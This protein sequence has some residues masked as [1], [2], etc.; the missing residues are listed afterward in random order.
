ML[1][2]HALN[3]GRVV[4][5]L[6]ALLRLYF[7]RVA[8]SS[9]PHMSAAA[10]LLAERR[11]GAVLLM[12]SCW[13]DSRVSPDA[14]SASRCAEPADKRLLAASVAAS[15]AFFLASSR[16]AVVASWRAKASSRAKRAWRSWDTRFS[17]STNN[18]RHWC[19]RAR[20]SS[21]RAVAMAV[22]SSGLQATM[23]LGLV[24]W[25]RFAAGRRCSWCCVITGSAAYSRGPADVGLQRPGAI[26]L[27]QRH[28]GQTTKKR[29]SGVGLS[30]CSA[31]RASA[32]GVNLCAAKWACIRFAQST[33]RRRLRRRPRGAAGASRIRQRRNE[34]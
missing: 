26:K 20:L 33:R 15:A 19:D 28:G 2:E 5:R 16:S 34:A 24:G 14:T 27:T 32:V 6:P 1:D 31:R 3:S 22:S 21:F 8:P 10:R 4:P 30:W 11:R 18:R 25:Q 17:R 23:E 12:R 29:A 13:N 7:P 9:A